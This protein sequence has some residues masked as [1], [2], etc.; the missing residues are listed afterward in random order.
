MTIS[1]QPT[2]LAVNGSQY[3]CAKCKDGYFWDG[4]ICDVC[5]EN[6]QSCHILKEKGTNDCVQCF[7]G[8]IRSPLADRC[9][10]EFDG[11]VVSAEEDLEIGEDA[12]Y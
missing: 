2:G 10:K 8:Y 6:C 12:E 9:V 3:F 7:P 4:E 11:C 5:T 1:T